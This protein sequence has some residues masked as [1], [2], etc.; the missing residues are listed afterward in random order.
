MDDVDFSQCCIVDRNRISARLCAALLPVLAS[1]RSVPACSSV[2]AAMCALSKE[3][4]KDAAASFG[5]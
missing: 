2:L 1:I 5:G 4:A 3:L